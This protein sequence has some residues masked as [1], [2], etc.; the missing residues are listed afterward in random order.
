MTRVT[1]SKGSWQHGTTFRYNGCH[2]PGC[3]E[4]SRL[5]LRRGHQVRPERQSGAVPV[6]CRRSLPPSRSARLQLSYKTLVIPPLIRHSANHV[7]SHCCSVVSG[8]ARSSRSYGLTAVRFVGLIGLMVRRAGLVVSIH[9]DNSAGRSGGRRQL[10]TLTGPADHQASTFTRS[11]RTRRRQDALACDP[12]TTYW[13]VS[14]NSTGQCI[15]FPRRGTSADVRPYHTPVGALS[16][17]ITIPE[18]PH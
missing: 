3:G 4:P 2:G 9:E 1:T 12:D 5:V 10:F 15:L 17:S 11:T 8:R 14:T 13:V 6:R 16:R 7:G 18:C